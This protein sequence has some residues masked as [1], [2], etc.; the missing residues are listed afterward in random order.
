MKNLTKRVY[1]RLE[2]FDSALAFLLA[3]DSEFR[4]P[5]I[6]TQ[7]TGKS[8]QVSHV[9]KGIQAEMSNDIVET[10]RGLRA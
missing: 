8:V 9:Q 3:V 5:F 6:L 2:R 1:I 4:N 7:S 10:F